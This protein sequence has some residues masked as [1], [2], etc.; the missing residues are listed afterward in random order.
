MWIKP[1]PARGLR[2]AQETM[3]CS[4]DP[5]LWKSRIAKG[6]D[7]SKTIAACISCFPKCICNTS[8]RHIKAC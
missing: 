7:S 6:L 4:N 1:N 5:P 8:S 3:V 2:L